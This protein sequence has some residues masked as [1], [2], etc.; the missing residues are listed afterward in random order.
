MRAIVTGASSGIGFEISKVL[1]N[2]GYEVFAIGRDFTK[3]DFNDKKFI[4]IEL[5]LRKKEEILKLKK[6]KNISILVNSAGVGYFGSYEQLSIEN[7]EEMI[8]IN[9]T[10]PL[11]ITRIFLNDLKRDSGYIFNINSISALKPAIYGVAYGATKAGLRHFGN[12]LF[13]E[14]RKSGLK[15]IN[16]NPDITKTAWFDKL[17]FTY[18]DDSQTYIEPK[19]IAKVVKNIIELGD[20]ATITDITIEPQKFKIVKKTKNF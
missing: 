3:I 1:V 16:I 18:S 13:N 8:W 14:A 12:S 2:L 4:K 11:I 15:V 19:S 5:D 20:T 17:D 10:T 7:I 9:L 6:I